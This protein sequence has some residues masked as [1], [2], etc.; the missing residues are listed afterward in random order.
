MK[1][2]ISIKG[3]IIESKGDKRKLKLIYDLIRRHPYFIGE[4]R[5]IYKYLIYYKRFE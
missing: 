2:N 4:R 1:E 5:K 3:L